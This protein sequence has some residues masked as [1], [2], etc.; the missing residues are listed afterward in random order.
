MPAVYKLS[1]ISRISGESK[2]IF[3]Q[4]NLRGVFVQIIDYFYFF[5]KCARDKQVFKE[6]N[7]KCVNILSPYRSVHT[8]HSPPTYVVHGE[9]L[10]KKHTAIYC[11]KGLISIAK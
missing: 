5:K 10:F 9:R 6:K 8:S 1:R 7:R 4:A 2:L 3:K 11:T